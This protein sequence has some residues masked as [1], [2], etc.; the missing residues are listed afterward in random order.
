MVSK[1]A[2]PSQGEVWLF[3][4]DKPCLILS[5]D[6]LNRGP[7]QLVIIVP[8]TSVKKGIASNVKVSPPQGGLKTVS[9]AMAEQIRTICKERLV[10]KMGVITDKS[11]LK[12]VHSWVLDLIWLS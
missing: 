3:D 4:K 5:C 11:I 9:F 12:E 1:K 6:D 8:F 7:S 2:D 10:K